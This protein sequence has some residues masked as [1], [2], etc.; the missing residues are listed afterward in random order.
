MHPAAQVCLPMMQVF[1]YIL[2]QEAIC[3]ATGKAFAPSVPI[4]EKL[5]WRED[6]GLRKGLP[7]ARHMAV[8][9]L[10]LKSCSSPASHS[11]FFS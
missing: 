11:N 3:L 6:I 8:C 5:N 1:T 2:E 7:V 10:L 9:N 4:A